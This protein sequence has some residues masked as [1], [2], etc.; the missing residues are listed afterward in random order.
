MILTKN[1]HHFLFVL[2]IAF[3]QHMLYNIGVRWSNLPVDRNN[4]VHLLAKKIQVL[5]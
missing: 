3:I 1:L 2:P 5:G 4:Y